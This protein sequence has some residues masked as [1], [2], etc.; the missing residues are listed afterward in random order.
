MQISIPKP[1]KDEIGLFY[2]SLPEGFQ[3]AT[4][5]DFHIHGKKNIGMTYLVEWN[6]QVRFSVR[7]V[8]DSF[9]GLKI[10]PFIIANKVFVLKAS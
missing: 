8:N 3:L 5:D 2:D 4:I 10:N 1:K 7:K 9:T 6:D